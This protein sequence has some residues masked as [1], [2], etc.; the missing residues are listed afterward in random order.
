MGMEWQCPKFPQGTLQ[1]AL[2]LGGALHKPLLFSARVHNKT[3]R[4]QRWPREDEFQPS[5]KYQRALSNQLAP[6]SPALLFFIL[7]IS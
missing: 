5:E 6:L 2:G 3:W 7:R 4:W 1:T